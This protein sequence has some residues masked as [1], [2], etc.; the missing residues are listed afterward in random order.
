MLPSTPKRPHVYLP[1]DFSAPLDRSKVVQDVTS[2]PTTGG[3]ASVSLSG[4]EWYYSVLDKEPRGPLT[5]A[6]I[7]QMVGKGIVDDE[8]WI[9]SQV[10]QTE[11]VRFGECTFFKSIPI[12]KPNAMP[13]LGVETA[14]GI[15][16]RPPRRPYRP[17]HAKSRTKTS[18]N[19]D[20]HS[21]AP[22]SGSVKRHGRSKAQERG[23]ILPKAS[24]SGGGDGLFFMDR[25]LEIEEVRNDLSKAEDEL[26]ERDAK[27]RQYKVCLVLAAR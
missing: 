3:Q 19:H 16:N 18:A 26:E 13:N 20:N 15:H 14:S 2:H 9:W 11:W 5:T 10:D 6:Q 22:A 24:E 4:G 21:G 12:P 23:D 1:Q 25:D 7:V 27:I 17:R 8:T